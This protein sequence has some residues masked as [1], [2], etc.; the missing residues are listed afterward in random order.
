MNIAIMADI[1]GNHIAL[2]AC[3]G[4][5]RKLGAEEFLFLGDYLDERHIRWF[6]Q[7][8]ISKIVNYPGLS[9]FVICHGS[10]WKVNESMRED[11]NSAESA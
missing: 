7:M 4:E 9:A 5:A 3:I 1:H 11:D 2:E 10:P 6:E 8:P